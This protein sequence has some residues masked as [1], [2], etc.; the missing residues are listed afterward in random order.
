MKIFISHSSYDKWVANEI[1]NHLLKKGHTTFLD[2]KDIKTGDSIDI[3]IQKH[4]K[5]SDHL[6][7]LI[8]PASLKSHWVFIEIG[9]AK[10]LEK[11]IVPILLYV[12]RNEIPNAISQLLARDI[13]EIDKYYEELI[14]LSSGQKVEP[15]PEI[16]ASKQKIEGFTVGEKIKIIDMSYLTDE[17]KERSPKWTKSMDKYSGVVTR[18]IGFTEQ[19]N[20][21]IAADNSE[22]R[23]APR[24][25]SKNTQ[26]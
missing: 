8:S 16:D 6:L 14:A 19:G 10:A 17:D 3:E 23:W 7:I 9:G 11:R 5:E 21:M 24:W 2:E 12:E 13:N 26:Q 4:L 22:F 20:A 15:L 1:S 18:I 25:L